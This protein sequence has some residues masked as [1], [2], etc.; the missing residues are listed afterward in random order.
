MAKRKTLSW[1]LC[2]LNNARDYRS[3][4]G[5]PRH[6]AREVRWAKRQTRRLLRRLLAAELKVEPRA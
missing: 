2:I 5:V 4:D 3:C 1:H 6:L